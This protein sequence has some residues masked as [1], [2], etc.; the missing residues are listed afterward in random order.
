MSWMIKYWN[1]L[2]TA[3]CMVLEVAGKFIY[4]IYKVG[5]TSLKKASDRIYYNEDISQCSS[6]NVLLRDPVERFV[7]GV[8]E[9]S[10][11]NDLP[12]EDTWD[13]IMNDKLVDRHF[14][15]QLFWLFHLYKFYKKDINLLPFSAIK[16]FTDIHLWS[17]EEKGIHNTPVDVI[18]KFV[19]M[20]KHLLQHINQTHNLGKLIERY[21]HVLS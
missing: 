8:N 12:L 5:Y 13:Q 7:S 14:S 3:D 4:P 2:L 20:D 1:K 17:Q 9:Y 18:D 15:P 10:Q 6:I 11:Q 16:D 21:Q 19:D